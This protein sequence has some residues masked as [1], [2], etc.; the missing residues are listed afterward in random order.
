MAYSLLLRLLEIVVLEE[1]LLRKNFMGKGSI[2]VSLPLS[3]QSVL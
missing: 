2:D 3:Y 1:V